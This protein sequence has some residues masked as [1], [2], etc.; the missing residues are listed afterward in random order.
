M[1]VRRCN[2][3]RVIPL[4]SSSKANS[5]YFGTEKEGILVDVGCSFGALKKSLAMFSI[6]LSAVKAV[7]ITH[8]HSDHVAGLFQLTKNTDIPVYASRGTIENIIKDVRVFCTDNLHDISE[9]ENAPVNMRISSFRTPHDTPESVGY[10]ME[11][12]GDKVSYCTD[13]GE[14]TE[15]VRG[16]VT[17]SRLVYLESNY[18]EGML[19]CNACYPPYLKKRISSDHGHLS[20]PDSAEFARQ[21]I[22]SGT[23]HFVLAHLSRENNTPAIARKNLVDT[24]LKDGMRENVDYSF[25][26]APVSAEGEYI[27][28]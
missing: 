9:L 23:T 3:A 26:V 12:D 6:D 2:M 25:M 15:E 28:L 21:L 27:S 18:D 10:S 13:L 24:L 11:I 14:I 16:A 5:A 17:G 22:K 19:R 7:C 8:E 4:C 20:N 1:S